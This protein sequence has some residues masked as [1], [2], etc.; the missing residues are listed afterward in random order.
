V[1]AALDLRAAHGLVAADIA[2]VRIATFHQSRRLATRAPATT[3]EAQYSTAF[4][5]AVAL[6]RGRVDPAYVMEP[7]FADPEIRRLAAAMEVVE[8][9]AFN[10]AF[11]A[12]RIASVTLTLGD[13]RVLTSGP[14]EARGDPEAPVAMEEVRAKFHAYA[15][16]GLGADRATAIEAEV[17][18]LGQGGDAAR[19]TDLITAPV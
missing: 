10:A 16:P 6:V 18:A 9:D 8:D 12:Q 2:G 15:D 4:P 3:E 17:D 11:P 13:G 1:Q 5:T 19:L 14:V 7:S